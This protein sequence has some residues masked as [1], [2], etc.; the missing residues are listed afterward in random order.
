MVTATDLKKLTDR[1]KR[2]TRPL[3]LHDQKYGERLVQMLENYS[4]RK[5]GVF[6]DPLEEAAFIL[7]IGMLKELDGESPA[8]EPQP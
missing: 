1:W 4:G 8:M 2:G 3:K 7:L 6:E 5:F